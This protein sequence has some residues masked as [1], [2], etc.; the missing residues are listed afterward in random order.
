MRSAMSRA[1]T[2]VEILCVVV[3]L[4]I[5]AAIVI[6]SISHASE[7]AAVN[8]TVT[9]LVR[10][11]KAV[12]VYRARN[13]DELPPIEEV[14]GDPEA[15]WGPLVG[16][17][18]DYLLT[19][20]RNMYVGGDNAARVIVVE[21]YEPDAEFHDDYGWVFVSST[22]DVYAASFDSEDRPIPRE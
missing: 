20:P 21:E 10:L 9:D 22:G 19:A 7:D 14:D 15:S 4:G 2:L 17:T 18:G 6:P 11:R 12:G 1:F 5:L 13:D 3:I 8:A 16:N